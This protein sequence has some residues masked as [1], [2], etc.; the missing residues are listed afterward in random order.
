MPRSLGVACFR[1]LTRQ[2]YLQSHLHRIAVKNFAC[3]H[4]CHQGEMVGD[5]LRH[6]GIV[7]KFFVDNSMEA[8]FDFFSFA[9][10]SFYWAAR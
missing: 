1:L 6:C 9:S 4:M 7:L 2:D 3:C 5:H 8:N 10:S